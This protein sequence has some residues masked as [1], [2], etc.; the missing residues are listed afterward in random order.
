M[1]CLCI[2]QALMGSFLSCTNTSKRHSQGLV[3]VT[4]GLMTWAL[5]NDL[6]SDID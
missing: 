3:R 2:L 4:F 6:D 1:A 5:V